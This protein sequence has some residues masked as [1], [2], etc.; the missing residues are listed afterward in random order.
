MSK[1]DSHARELL[2]MVDMALNPKHFVFL[3]YEQFLDLF[4]KYY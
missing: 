3:L 4:L 2:G 1:L